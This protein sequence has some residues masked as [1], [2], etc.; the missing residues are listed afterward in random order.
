MIQNE[1]WLFEKN[2]LQQLKP[3]RQRYFLG[4]EILIFQHR[5]FFSQVVDLM[6][7]LH[8]DS[9]VVLNRSCFGAPLRILIIQD[10]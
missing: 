9:N 10:T 4:E 7:A 5:L 1:T 6:T 8:I 3:P 2:S